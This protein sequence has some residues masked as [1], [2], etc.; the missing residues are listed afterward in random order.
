MA[1]FTKRTRDLLTEKLAGI[2]QGTIA[3]IANVPGIR[4][5]FEDRLAIIAGPDGVEREVIVTVQD[6]NGD[7]VEYVN[8]GTLR[9][10]LARIAS[11]VSVTDALAE[12][13]KGRAPTIRRGIIR[14]KL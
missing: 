1:T 11:G 5:A 4:G 9:S 12:G 6:G 10:W 8:I 7:A 13:H 3:S 14:I 2:P